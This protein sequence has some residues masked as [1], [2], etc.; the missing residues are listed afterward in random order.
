MPEAF[1]PL[2]Q[3]LELTPAAA[4]IAA[5]CLVNCSPLLVSSVVSLNLS[6][7]EELFSVAFSGVG[8]YDGEVKSPF[9]SGTLALT[10]HRVWYF[11][12]TASKKKGSA[13][14]D[15]AVSFFWLRQ[16]HTPTGLTHYK[17]FGTWSHPKISFALVP[18][19]ALS[20]AE[21]RTFKFSFREG[22]NDAFHTS[23]QQCLQRRLWTRVKPPPSHPP[24]VGGSQGAQ[25]FTSRDNETPPTTDAAPL[26]SLLSF[27]DKAGIGGLQRRQNISSV[28]ND[29]LVTNALTDVDSVLTNATALIQ[30]IKKIRQQ[31]DVEAERDGPAASGSSSAVG[32]REED[33]RKLLSLEDALGLSAHEYASATNRSGSAAQ[34][35]AQEVVAWLSHPANASVLAARYLI[36]VTELYALYNSKA[37]SR[38]QQLITPQKLSEA[39]KELVKGRVVTQGVPYS[40]RTFRCGVIA[41]L[42][43]KD[44][45]S[46][47]ETFLGPVP[48]SWS[49]LHHPAN[50]RTHVTSAVR[51]SSIDATTLAQQLQVHITVAL[52][53][54][55]EMESEAKLCRDERRSGAHGDEDNVCPTVCRFSWNVFLIP[56]KQG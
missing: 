10:S 20:A 26:D 25:V 3:T 49:Q 1:L 14:G 8:V 50:R 51:M 19:D 55:E 56:L 34:Q 28:T 47:M 11:F 41:L 37:R 45:T 24:H 23:L 32:L 9:Q 35:L 18:P 40:L 44:F 46:L 33:F 2:W 42:C 13:P 12:S 43:T 39:L 21:P 48:T 38:V 4:Q 29:A 53:L 52:E 22:G 36:P 31:I 27:T 16:M 6:D 30:E 17:G 15:V 54:L 7:P 5:S